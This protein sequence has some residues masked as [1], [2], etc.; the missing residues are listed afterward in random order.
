MQNKFYFI[1]GGDA[2]KIIDS[3]EYTNEDGT[4]NDEGI[5]QLS[6]IPYAT[7]EYDERIHNV[8]NVLEAYDGYND[9]ANIDKSLFDQ[10]QS[11]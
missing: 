11:L 6:L 7:F 8:F 3:P 5:E 1:F 9:Y 10:I 4:L 2:C